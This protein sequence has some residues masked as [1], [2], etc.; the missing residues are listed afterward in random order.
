MNQGGNL[1][2]TALVA[3][4]KSRI[5]WDQVKDKTFPIKASVRGKR[6]PAAPWMK[7]L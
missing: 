2:R 7:P 6:R 3:E 5:D 4:K 1:A